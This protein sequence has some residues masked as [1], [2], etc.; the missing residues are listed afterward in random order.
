MKNDT[1]NFLNLVSYVSL[2]LFL[3]ASPTSR[4]PVY[5]CSFLLRCYP[6]WFFKF[7]LLL[8]LL[9]FWPHG[10]AKGILASLTGMEPGSM[11]LKA[12]SL[13]HWT[14]REFLVISF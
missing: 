13:N 14:S 12:P 5:V 4:I 1:V 6:G 3:S 7:H 8:L 10:T 9:L 11:A 2:L